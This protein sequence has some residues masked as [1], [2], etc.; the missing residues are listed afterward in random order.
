MVI[1][2]SDLSNFNQL[3]TDVNQEVNVEGLRNDVQYWSESGLRSDSIDLEMD[4]NY[5]LLSLTV[6][7]SSVLAI[8][9]LIIDV[10]KGVEERRKE[11]L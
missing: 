5:G 8:L 6:V 11:E 2:R 1:F 9:C 4:I 3:Y 10:R 7:F